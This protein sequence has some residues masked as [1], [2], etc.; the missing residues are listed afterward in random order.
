MLM[1]RVGY[2]SAAWLKEKL[3]KTREKVTSKKN[4]QEVFPFREF[5]NIIKAPLS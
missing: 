5:L 3:I 1:D 2:F 4:K